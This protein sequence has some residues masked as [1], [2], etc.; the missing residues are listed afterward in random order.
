MKKHWILSF[1]LFGC[2]RVSA[3]L[4]ISFAPTL[5]SSPDWQVVFENFVTHRHFPFLRNG[6]AASLDY[7]VEFNQESIRIRP[8]IQY[9]RATVWHYPHYFEV[10][11]GGL[12]C[13]FDMALMGAEEAGGK[14]RRFRPYLEL[15]PGLDRVNLRYDLP[16][17]DQGAHFT[18]KYQVI[19]KHGLAFSAEAAILLEF[20]LSRLLSFSPELGLRFYPKLNWEGFSRTVSGGQI[21]ETFDR[22]NWRQMYVGVRLELNLS[23]H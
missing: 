14:L 16:I 13:K 20:Q 15:S 10:T 1:F 9:M 22:T 11:T 18:G 23:A 21:E 5:N 3:Q 12:R 6:M 19:K 4:G 7:A 17:G 2:L 8:T